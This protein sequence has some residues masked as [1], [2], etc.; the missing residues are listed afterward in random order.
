MDQDGFKVI[1]LFLVLPVIFLLS[2]SCEEK[3]FS[4]QGLDQTFIQDAY[5]T[6]VCVA[7]SPFP[8]HGDD[9]LPYS[10][11]HDVSGIYNGWSIAASGTVIPSP[12]PGIPEDFS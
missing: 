10:P 12:S 9:E 4:I 7:I 8:H 6:S 5:D 11:Y 3:G 1:V 2:G